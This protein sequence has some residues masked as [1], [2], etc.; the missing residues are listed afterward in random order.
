[1][2]RSERPDVVTLN[3]ICRNDLEVLRRAMP[4]RRDTMILSAF[5]PAM[6]RDTGGPFLCRNGQP[7]GIGVLARAH[8]SQSRP[9]IYGGTYLTQDLGDPE[10]R[11]WLCIHA[12][13]QFY[14]CTTHTAS[15]STAIALAQCRYLMQIALPLVV[16]RGGRDPIVLGADLNLPARGAPGPQDCVPRGYHRAD[17]GY[18][19][20]VVTSPEFTVRSQSDINMHGTTDHPGLLVDVARTGGSPES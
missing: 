1:V 20:D 19:Q 6:N 5:K 2:I 7:Y 4:A 17:D 8:S 11:V 9:H 14:A 18:L 12:A 10:E 13:N 16:E 3:E 15:T